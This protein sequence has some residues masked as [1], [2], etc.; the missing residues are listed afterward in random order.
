MINKQSN[1]YHK[2]EIIIM[3]DY[4]CSTEEYEALIY[5]SKVNRYILIGNLFKSG[6][7]KLIGGFRDRI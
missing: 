3:E 6:W 5:S 2:F 7:K 1:C 4:Y